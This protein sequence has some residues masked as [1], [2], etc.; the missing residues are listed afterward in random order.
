MLVEYATSGGYPI[1]VLA[2][3]DG[4]DAYVLTAE[5]FRIAEALRTPVVVLTDK[6]TSKTLETVDVAAL[7][8][9]DVA[10]ARGPRP[11][12]A[13]RALPDRGPRRRAPLRTGRAA[14]RKVTTTGSAHDEQGRLR[15]NDP[16]TLRQ[17]EHLGAKIRA[18]AGELERVRHRRMDGAT[19]VV[20]S[21][22]V[23]A[24][25]CRQAVGELEA[26]GIPV[27]LLEIL[28]LFPVPEGALAAAVEGRTRVVVVEENERGLYAR[29][30]RPHLPADRELVT[31]QRPG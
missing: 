17:L 26:E 4:A 10:G 16:S 5:A 24:R 19:T 12:G 31:R 30:L 18:R 7:P 1:P 23:S 3:V 21:F 22:G 13:L 2:P 6:E 8:A 14:P 29:E 11:R 27:D 15:K 28:S 9:I 25:A 20:V